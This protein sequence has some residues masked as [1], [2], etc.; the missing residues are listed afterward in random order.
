VSLHF[1]Q[2][3]SFVRDSLQGP[4]GC[5]LRKSRGRSCHNFLGRCQQSKFSNCIKCLL[6]S[7]VSQA[8]VTNAGLCRQDMT[9]LFANGLFVRIIIAK[10]NNGIGAF[11]KKLFELC[12]TPV[13]SVGLYEHLLRI[14][15]QKVVA[16]SKMNSDKIV[17]RFE[18]VDSRPHILMK[19]ENLRC[20][21][22]YIGL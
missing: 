7:R 21:N 11:L 2:K 8:C 14:R 10:E 15:F 22:L 18:I 9:L 13:S 17:T 19:I 5:H 1:I 20:G 4:Q 3:N 6:T 12:G 16:K